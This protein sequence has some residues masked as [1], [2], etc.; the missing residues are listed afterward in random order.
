MEP[1][2]ERTQRIRSIEASLDAVKAKPDQN[3]NQKKIMWILLGV[4][5]I[6]LGVA[7]SFFLS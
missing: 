5:V 3:Q 6:A 1:L 4:I 7:F 2:D